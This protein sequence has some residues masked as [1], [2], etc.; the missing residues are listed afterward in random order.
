MTYARTMLRH[1]STVIW[2]ALM[3][4][5]IAS[6]WLGT[7]HNFL[8]GPQFATAAVLAIAFVKVAMVTSTFMEIDHAPRPLKAFV[9]G[10]TILVCALLVVLYVTL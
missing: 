3:I 8:G 7:D 2:A 1:R 6:W 9:H 10:W 4:A 5:T